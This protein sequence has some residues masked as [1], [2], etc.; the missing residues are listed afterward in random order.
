MYINMLS[1]P[2]GPYSRNMHR[3]LGGGTV[4]FERGTPIHAIVRGLEVIRGGD[5]RRGRPPRTAPDRR[6]LQ[7][8]L[9]HVRQGRGQRVPPHPQKRESRAVPSAFVGKGAAPY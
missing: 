4:S 8:P 3:P 1:A 9:H 2:L 7:A 6:H 5:I